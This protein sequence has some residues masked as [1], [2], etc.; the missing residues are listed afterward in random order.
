MLAVVERNYYDD[1]IKFEIVRRLLRDNEIDVNLENDEEETA[2]DI[3][4]DN[5]NMEIALILQRAEQ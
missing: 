5:D 4:N 1:E 3:A 2:L